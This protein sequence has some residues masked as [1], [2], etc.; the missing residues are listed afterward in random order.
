MNRGNIWVLGLI[1]YLMKRSEV[2][3][4]NG[5]ILKFLADLTKIVTLTKITEI[6]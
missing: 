4:Y 6:S 1:I 2:Y 5:K 3:E